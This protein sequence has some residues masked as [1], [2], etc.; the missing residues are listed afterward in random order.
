[1]AR[2]QLKDLFQT[3]LENH[4]ENAEAAMLGGIDS[5]EAACLEVEE[6]YQEVATVEQDLTD[7]EDIEGG[8]ESVV[9]S[10][11]AA[12]EQGG[13]DATSAQFAHHAVGAYTERLGIE[14]ADLLPGLESF[15]GDSGRQS[16]TTVSLESVG[17]TLKK[18][19]NAIKAAVEKA[20]KAV[21]DFFAKIFGGVSKI[22]GRIDA[23][24]KEVAEAKKKELSD[25]AKIK[26][27]S[28]NSLQLGGKVDAGALTK[29]MSN[30]V[31]VNKN[32][33]GNAVKDAE[34]AYKTQATEIT[35]LKDKDDEGAAEAAQKAILDKA[36][37]VIKAVLKTQGTIL[38]GDKTF[39]T[40]DK[41]DGEKESSSV[42]LQTAKN[43]K[44]FAGS[45]EI[46]ALTVAQMEGLLKDAEEAIKH[47]KDSKDTIEKVKKARQDAMDA[48]KKVVDDSDRG[49][50]GK[51]WTKG[52]AQWTLRSTQ[53]DLLRPVTQL[54]SHNF[55]VLRS[56]LAVVESSTKQYKEKKSGGE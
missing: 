22:E 50:V 42:S 45:N 8:L 38:P 24:K 48:A 36:N 35:K 4:D 55:S 7:L 46:D 14:S 31:D 19:W 53:R 37:D 28:A 20:I 41:T 2:S 1:M 56:V 52:K 34:E 9:E 12:L 30:L 15:G 18:I 17:E 44:A 27:G 21:T 40:E 39:V 49:R 23:L 10:L 43:A 33:F 47:L 13:L 32:V 16:A 51:V 29:G 54:A 26:V 3:S 5:M 25:K 11:E 6:A